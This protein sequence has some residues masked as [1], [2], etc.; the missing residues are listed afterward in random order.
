MVINICKFIE[1]KNI[2]NKFRLFLLGLFS[3]VTI[4]S[5]T[6]DNKLTIE[7]DEAAIVLDIDID[8][9]ELDENNLGNPAL[10]LSWSDATYTVPTEVKYTIQFSTEETFATFEVGGVVIANTNNT[11][12]VSALNSAVSGA[13]ATPFA[14]T[15]MYARVIASVGSQEEEQQISNIVAF[16]VYSFYNYPY[17]DIF[18]VGPAS[19]SGWSNDNVN[20]A[21]IRDAENK[22]IFSYTGFLKAD[23]LKM[24]EVRGQWAPQYGMESAGVLGFRLTESDPDPSPIDG[25]SAEG[26][27]SF[28]VNIA[29]LTYTLTEYTDD[30]PTELTSLNITGS[31]VDSSTSMNQYSVDGGSTIWDEHIWFIDSVH[32]NQGEIKFLAN[33]TDNWGG[34]TSFSGASVADGNAIT[35]VVEDDYEVW[36][37]AIT[38][39]YHM[40]PINLSKK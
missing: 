23:A 1:M 5:C 26:Y 18:L 13:G 29:D 19:A 12:S 32:L 20:A 35:I 2:L 14:W 8:I 28:E 3:I 11:W 24:V 7:T 15:N 31:A 33:G 34:D 39:Q 38:K 9:I 25:V 21:M 16:E 37:N 22:N 27:W 17:K 40:I 6:D 36:F 30:L 10:T 4:I